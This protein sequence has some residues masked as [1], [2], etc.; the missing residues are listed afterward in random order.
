M[1]YHPSFKYNSSSN[2]H[3]S[4]EMR[5]LFTKGNTASKMAQ[6]YNFPPGT[7]NTPPIAIVSLGG[8]YKMADLKE[9]WKIQGIPGT[10]NVRH[11]NVGGTL[12]RPEQPFVPGDGSEENTLDLEIVTSMCPTSPVI[13]YFGRND[14]TGFLQAITA[15]VMGPAKIISISWGGSEDT[16]NGKVGIEAYEQVFRQAQRVGKIVVAAT[17]DNGSSDGGSK[18]IT[19][20]PSCSPSVLACGGTS[21]LPD[22]QETGW[23][24]N[25]QKQWGTGGGVSKYFPVPDYQRGVIEPYSG[26]ATPDLALLADPLTGWSIYFN[27]KL[28]VNSWGGTSAVAP[29]MAALL[30]CYKM[31]SYANLHQQIYSASSTVAFKDIVLGTNASLPNDKKSYVAKKGHDLVT[32]W[33]SIHG[34]NLR[35]ALLR[36][37]VAKR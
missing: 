18:L 30:A 35:L 34:G 8:S 5:Q 33:G 9:Y 24:W 12:N 3:L 17:G 21:L 22:G 36:Q 31:P 13:I 25:P 32:G 26:R 28:N 16:F 1:S 27:G 2:D 37:S 11:V 14:Y 23:S 10:P 20:Y 6:Y 4:T 29:A 19:D 15:A 7:P